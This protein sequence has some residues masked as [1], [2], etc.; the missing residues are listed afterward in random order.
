MTKKIN[1]VD[2]IL[3]FLSLISILSWTNPIIGKYFR[4][5]YLLSII[6][7][8]FE[9]DFFKKFFSNVKNFSFVVFFFIFKH[10]ICFFQKY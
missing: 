9:K 5:I 1:Y 8:F 4:F 7:I 10:N 6:L 3:I 2:Y